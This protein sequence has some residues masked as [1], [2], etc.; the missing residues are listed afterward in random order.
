MTNFARAW[1]SNG[2]TANLGE[3]GMLVSLFA[4]LP[5]TFSAG[6]QG[7][8]AYTPDQGLCVFNGSAWVTVGN[9]TG[10]GA[11]QFASGTTGNLGASQDNY[12]PAGYVAGVTNRMLLL[13]LPGDSS[14]LGI[15][16]P[17]ADGWTI[18]I[19]NT[20]TIDNIIFK[21]AASSTSANKFACPNSVDY[22]LPPQGALLI[23]YII[24]QWELLCVF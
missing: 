22:Y 6:H 5:T 2:V 17:P 14:L 20:S 3:A 16:A 19:K 13:A 7:S 23:S 18:L 12:A 8:L 21:Q 4:A 1:K 10:G 15:V 11:V 9:V 24:N